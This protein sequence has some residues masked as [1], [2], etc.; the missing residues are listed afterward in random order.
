MRR[1]HRRPSARRRSAPPVG[2]CPNCGAA[3]DDRFC[4]G[5]GQRNAERL[6]SARRLLAEFVDEQLG[7]NGA[8]PR[9]L[10][11]LVFR[12]G[13]LT[14]DYLAGRIARYV[15]P[16][17]LYLGASLVFFLALST[18]A[19]FDALARLT[20]PA[21]ERVA[22]SERDASG[23]VVV[24]RTGIDTAGVPG[25]LRPAAAH[26]VR[27]EAKI[28]ALPPREGMRVL[29][30]AAF[31]DV[32][33]VV[34]LL[35]P[36]FALLLKVLYRR[37]WYVEHLVFVLHL[38]AFAFLL[39]AVALAT[40]QPAAALMVAAG[41]PVYLLIAMRRVYPGGALVLAAKYLALV[42]AYLGALG[43]VAALSLVAGVLT[44]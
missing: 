41:L 9:T 25:W 44:A 39:C 30:D 3:V 27:R 26:Y 24:V 4:P 17:R 22:G 13:A 15:P 12:P 5:C 19:S 20:E 1:V 42:I 33:I 40:R 6:V 31:R 10:R 35:V 11:L 36:G 2:E 23:G 28:N 34:F 16:I 8:L 7:V 38:H 21:M 29:Y 14:R 18:V 43:V 37:R 32:P